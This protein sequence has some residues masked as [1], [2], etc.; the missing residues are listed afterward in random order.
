REHAAKLLSVGH[1]SV[2]RACKVLEK[3]IPALIEAVDVCKLAVST[4]ADLAEFPKEEQT[5]LLAAGRAEIRKALQKMQS[6]QKRAQTIKQTHGPEAAD[7]PDEPGKPFH[8]TKLPP[9]PPEL[10][11][12][13][14]EVFNNGWVKL[15]KDGDRYRMQL[16]EYYLD[17]LNRAINRPLFKHLVE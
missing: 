11:K 6:E 12:K 9:L 4:A 17:E 14:M 16:C 2:D 15:S 7:F 13:L 3:G 8:A 1:S 5:R 10:E